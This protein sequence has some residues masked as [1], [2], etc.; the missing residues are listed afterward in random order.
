MWW[1][2]FNFFIFLIINSTR[3]NDCGAL[4]A[5][6]VGLAL[7]D[8]EASIVAPFSS[9]KKTIA[10][11]VLL[12]TYWFSIHN[13]FFDNYEEKVVVL[14]KLHLWLLNIWF[15][16]QSSNWPLLWL[17][18]GFIL[19]WETSNISTLTWSWFSLLPLQVFIKY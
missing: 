13:P 6:H 4:K 8:A 3:T 10:D 17:F 2:V 12:I 11:V 16:I 19:L 15:Y 1:W 9:K 18:T 14:F 5:A 7:S